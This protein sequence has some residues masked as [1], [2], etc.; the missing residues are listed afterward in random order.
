M[1][2]AEAEPVAGRLLGDPAADPLEAVLGRHD[3]VCRRVQRAAQPLAVLVVGIPHD[4]CP[5]TLRSA[6]MPRVM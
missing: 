6:D 2:H 3:A 5:S 1:E 4:S